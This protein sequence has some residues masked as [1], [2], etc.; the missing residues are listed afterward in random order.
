MP[1]TKP[2][3]GLTIGETARRSGCNIETVRY[4]ERIGLVPK[5][6][7]S[8][9]GHRLY[10]GNTVSRLAFIRRAREL[11]FAIGDIRAL[12]GLVDRRA[13]N[14][15]EVKHIAEKQLGAVQARIGD[16]RQLERDLEGMI[17]LCSGR[18]IPDCPI[19]DSL[20][21]RSGARA[22]P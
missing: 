10:G 12:L 20:F 1:I 11:G 4:Y 16:L 7:R 6:P 19:I 22:D 5:P 21:D 9:G 14:C 17:S 13:A 18:R 3:P 15:R 2:R 8:G